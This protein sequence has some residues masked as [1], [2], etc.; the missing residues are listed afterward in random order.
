MQ[1]NICCSMYRTLG[2]HPDVVDGAAG[3]RFAVW[4]PNAQ[5]GFGR[6][7]CQRLETRPQLAAWQRFGN[8]VRLHARR[9]ATA[10]CT[11]TPPHALTAVLIEKSDPVAFYAEVPPNSASVVFHLPDFPWQDGGWMRK[12]PETNWLEQPLSIYEVHLGS[13]KRPTDGRPYFNYR[14]LA[15]ML[16]DY[17][18]EMGYTH[19]QLMPICEYPFDG[20]W[21]YQTTGY[22]APTSRHGTPTDFMYF[23][24]YCHQ[25]NVGVLIDWVPAHF[26]CDGH[27]LGALRRHGP[28]R[29]RRSAAR[30]APRLG[31]VH[32]QLRPQRSPRF[33]DV[34]RPLLAR[35]L[36]R[37]RAPRR[38]RRLDALSRLFAARPGS[39]SPT[40]TAAAKTSRR[41]S[42]S[43]ISTSTCTAPFPASSR[44]PKNRPPGA[45]FRIPCTPAV[46]ASA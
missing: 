5:G 35:R 23:V 43:R 25:A 15:H 42:S 17:A 20:S 27:G 45:A 31:N 32:L 46:S 24:D 7:Q 2:A 37:R 19:L 12:R 36:P 30:N 44:L 39:G 16:V 29:A 41:S 22:F 40:N 8:L 1:G 4:A 34:E 11:N 14:E 21:G 13:W 18:H 10:T 6:L 33:P 38:R 3:T 26:P 28:V 9:R